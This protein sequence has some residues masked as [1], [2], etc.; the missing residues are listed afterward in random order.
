MLENIPPCRV[1]NKPVEPYEYPYKRYPSLIF[2]VSGGWHTTI[3]SNC[4]RFNHER[5]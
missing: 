4:N 3:C 2:T 1:C 5:N